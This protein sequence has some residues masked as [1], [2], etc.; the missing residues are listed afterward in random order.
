MVEQALHAPQVPSQFTGSACCVVAEDVGESVT[1]TVTTSE[2]VPAVVKGC[3]ADVSASEN[4]RTVVPLVIA[5][6][7]NEDRCDEATASE[8]NP[9]AVALDANEDV[10]PVRS[11]ALVDPDMC[12]VSVDPI[13]MDIWPVDKAAMLVTGVKGSVDTVV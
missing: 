12:C 2:L 6:D 4:S 11:L 9:T 8:V 10:V 7:E 5:S 13:S 1:V 3:A